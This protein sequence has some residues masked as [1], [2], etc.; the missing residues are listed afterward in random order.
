MNREGLWFDKF[1]THPDGIG[2]H[3]EGEVVDGKGDFGGRR[4]ATFMFQAM[5]SGGDEVRDE[6]D[7]SSQEEAVEKIRQLGLYPTSVRLKSAVR[8]TAPAARAARPAAK[9]T[10]TIGGV[11]NKQLCMLTRQ[12]STLQDAGLP[13]VRSVRILGGQLKPGLLK[14]VLDEVAED[15]ESEALA[16]LVINRLRGALAPPR[17]PRDARRTWR[18]ETDSGLQIDTLK[19]G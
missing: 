10:I 7:A 18:C 2:K 9:R 16:T 12:L 1:T 8:T 15:V 3:V 11:S 13:L 4:M 6:I 17:E 14:N 19:V 5:N